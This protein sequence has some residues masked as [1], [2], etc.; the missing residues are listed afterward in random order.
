MTYKKQRN[1][2]EEN[3]KNILAAHREMDQYSEKFMKKMKFCK[4]D[5]YIG[6][7]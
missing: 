1:T 7:K 2:D 6:S 5:G 3:T 4:D